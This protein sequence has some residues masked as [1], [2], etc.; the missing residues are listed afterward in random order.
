MHIF[1]CTQWYTWLCMLWLKRDE[2]IK[3]KPQWAGEVEDWGEI[4]SVVCSLISILS[5][6]G[7]FTVNYIDFCISFC[8]HL[9]QL[10]YGI[11]NMICGWMKMECMM[12]SYLCTDNAWVCGAWR[13][14]G[15]QCAGACGAW[16]GSKGTGQQQGVGSST[17]RCLYYESPSTSAWKLCFE[18]CWKLG[19]ALQAAHH[20][21]Y[22]HRSWIQGL[23]CVL[24]AGVCP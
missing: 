22:L 1:F 20:H 16:N 10:Q 11:H 3:N 24:E 17:S 12:L 19:R 23:C 15:V 4:V 7:W 9:F 18:H 8:V 13:I 5:L 21:L 6:S 2:D 14:G